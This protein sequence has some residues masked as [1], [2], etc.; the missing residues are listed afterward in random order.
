VRRALAVAAVVLAALVAVGFWYF[1]SGRTRLTATPPAVLRQLAGA[2]RLPH[3]PRSVVVVVEENK[4]F[5]TMRDTASAP[6]IH[7]LAARGALF[8]RSYGVA[9]PSQPNYFALFAG[10]VDTNGDGCPAAGV[11]PTAPNLGAELLAAHR[12]FRAYVEDLPSP[13]YTGCTYGEYARKHAPWTNFSN[14]PPSAAVPFSALRSYAALPD[15]AF[16][17]PNLLDDMHSGSIARGDAWLRKNV[18]PLV[19]WADRNDGLVIVTWDESDKPFSNHIMTIFVGPMVAPGRYD[20]PIDHYSVLR[21]IEDLFS[22]PHA[23]RSAAAAP[24]AGIWR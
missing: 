21:T 19:A 22:L 10:V 8:T 17:I 9:H 12:S 3:T 24:I 2:L 20:Q 4:S 14:I 7:E 13:G 11:S 18:G 23:G 6:Y 1:G 5:E 15:V 16:V